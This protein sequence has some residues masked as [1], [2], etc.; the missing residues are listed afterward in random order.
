MLHLPDPGRLVIVGAGGFGRECL[1]IIDAL[2][3]VGARIEFAGFTDDGGGDAELLSRRGAVCVGPVARTADHADRYVI[4]IGSPS[5]RARIDQLVSKSGL[6][7]PVLVHP[8]ATL[9]SACRVA[10]GTILNAGARVTTNISLG[11]HVQIHCNATIGHDSVLDDYVSVF[12]GAT[13]SGNVHLAERV[14]VGTGANVIP[15]VSVGAGA[16]IGAGA[17]VIDDVEPNA[18]VVGVPARQTLNLVSRSARDQ[19]MDPS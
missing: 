12:P 16:T 5:A 13:I 3:A 7:A 1:D 2:N 9:G 18:T 19:P 15:G 8:Q 17:V 10:P 6:A 14:T 11:R 4:G